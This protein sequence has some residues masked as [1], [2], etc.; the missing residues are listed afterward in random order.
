MYITVCRSIAAA[1]H[2]IVLSSEKRTNEW[3]QI[4]SPVYYIVQLK[5]SYSNSHSNWIRLLSN[6]HW[7]KIDAAKY[8]ISIYSHLHRH[9]GETFEI[10]IEIVTERCEANSKK[11][12][13]MEIFLFASFLF[14]LYLNRRSNSGISF[15]KVSTFKWDS[16]VRWVFFFSSSRNK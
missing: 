14:F 4:K 3:N 1:A 2:S 8:S 11:W 10:Y 15:S 12:K 5:Y 9:S 7:K 13:K 6:T 16:F